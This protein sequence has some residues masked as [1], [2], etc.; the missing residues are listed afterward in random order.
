MS[1]TK[2]LNS[3]DEVIESL[4][5]RFHPENCQNMKASFHWVLTG[6]NGQEFT[7]FIDDGT[8]KVE[9]G[10]REEFDV[11][12]EIDASDYLRLVNGELK[13]MVAIM[14]RKLKVKGPLAL[15]SKLDAIFI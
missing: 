12:M 7:I 3:V 13:G 1:E 9:R 4:A 8:F 11:R 14:T 5:G 6:D 15:G 10:P 2:K